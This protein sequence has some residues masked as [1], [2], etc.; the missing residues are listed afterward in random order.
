MS[1]KAVISLRQIKIVEKAHT[2]KEKM[3]KAAK[4]RNEM[5]TL[6]SSHKPSEARRS[7]L[8]ASSQTNWKKSDPHS[9]MTVCDRPVHDHLIA[10]HILSRYHIDG[11]LWATVACTVSKHT[12]ASLKVANLCKKL[13]NSRRRKRRDQPVIFMHGVS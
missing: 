3:W 11:C 4:D 8:P 7:S 10:A 1:R 13:Q 6:R 5:G 9:Y 12:I 2:A